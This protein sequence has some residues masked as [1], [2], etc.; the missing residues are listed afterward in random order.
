MQLKHQNSM[1]QLRHQQNTSLLKR[2]IRPVENQVKVNYDVAC[3]TEDR[4]ASV[5]M[6]ARNYLERI[7][8]GRS[9]VL[10]SSYVFAAEMLLFEMEF[11]WF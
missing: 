5:A 7:V 10:S 9:R 1:N 8:S 3:L 4:R 6:L 2:W 11:N